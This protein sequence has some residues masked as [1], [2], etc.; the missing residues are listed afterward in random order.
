MNKLKEAV[1]TSPAIRPID[2]T[3]KA[4]SMRRILPSA[5]YVRFG[6]ITMNER[7]ARFS[8]PKRELYGLLRALKACQY[9]LIGIRNL[10]VETDAQYIKGMLSNPGMG[11]NAT[12]N[13]WIEDILMF[14][15]TLRHVKGSTFPADGLSRRDAQPG[16]EVHPDLK[17][18]ELEDHGP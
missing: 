7:E 4:E 11:P 2:L 15:F 3:S 5:Y 6:S 14:H 8:Q 10:V 13:R 12:I 18:Y 17:D 16:D 1:V 9:W